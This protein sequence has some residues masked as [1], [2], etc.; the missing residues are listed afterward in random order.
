MD[1]TESKMKLERDEK[2]VYYIRSGGKKLAAAEVYSNPFHAGNAYLRI[3]AEDRRFVLASGLIPFIRLEEARPLEAV[4]SNEDQ[5]LCALLSACGFSLRRRCFE[6][7]VTESDLKTELAVPDLRIERAGN[8]A[9]HAACSALLFG[10]Y[11]RTHEAINPLTA[12]FEEFCGQLPRE[13]YFVRSSERVSCAAFIEDNELA[14]VCFE[15]GEDAPRFLRAVVGMLFSR[16]REV[17]FEA[18]DTDPAAMEL[19][20]LFSCG[21]LAEY[22]TYIME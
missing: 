15:D 17:V 16:F 10:H 7:R 3:V 19:M 20:A 6:M 5:E 13:A 21:A 22:D 18:D 4:V 8:K 12:S 11:R 1:G 14:Y 9:E 2:G